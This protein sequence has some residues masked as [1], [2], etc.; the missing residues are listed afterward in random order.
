MAL[1]PLSLTLKQKIFV[2][3]NFYN[4]DEKTDML[5][6]YG[7]CGKNSVASA[8]VY[9]PTVDTSNTFYINLIC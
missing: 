9:K 5:L 7:E 4:N 2:N 6:I 8:V 3:S 1:S